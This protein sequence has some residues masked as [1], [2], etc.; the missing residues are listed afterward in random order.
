MK[1][2]IGFTL[3]E[4]LVVIAI[5]A[6]LMSILMPALG[7]AKE[8]AS[9]AVCLNNQK[10]FVLSFIMSIRDG[11][12][13]SVNTVFG[14]DNGWVEGPQEADGTPVAVGA[15]NLTLEHRLNGIRA[16]EFYPYMESVKAFH[17]PGDRRWIDGTSKLDSLTTPPANTQRYK[18]YVSYAFPDSIGVDIDNGKKGRAGDK[19]DKEKNVVRIDLTDIKHPGQK[20]IMLEDGYDANG[21]TNHGW[22]LDFPRDMTLG[23]PTSWEWHDPMGTYHTGGCTF[24]YA[25]GHADKYKWKDPRT[26]PYFRDR[27]D[28]TLSKSQP[29]NE[30][31]EFMLKHLPL[32]KYALY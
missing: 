25:D 30:D 14:V 22:G 18:P 21:P 23:S 12:G 4:L 15:A 3:I 28:S 6:L 29:E 7:K 31:I 9:M 20:Y 32:I 27:F 16:G 5:I 1:K 19:A 13:E 11:D 17:C 24:G 26:V 2:R 10:A 8:I